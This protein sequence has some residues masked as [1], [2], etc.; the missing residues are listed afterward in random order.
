[1]GIYKYIQEAWKVPKESYVRDLLWERMQ[2]WRREPAVVRIE[3]PTRI[4][5]ARNLA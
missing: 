4:D 3:R 2:K 1:M 5:R